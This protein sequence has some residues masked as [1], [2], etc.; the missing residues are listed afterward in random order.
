ML[1]SA[2]GQVMQCLVSPAIPSP[3]PTPTR[4]PHSRLPDPIYLNDRHSGLRLDRKPAASPST[5][6]C[7]ARHDLRA[8]DDAAHSA[9]AL[10]I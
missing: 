5:R 4:Y 6:L 2:A 8:P 10:K 3:N 1:A 9:E 7:L